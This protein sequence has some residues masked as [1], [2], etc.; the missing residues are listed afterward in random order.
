MEGVQCWL[1]IAREFIFSYF[2]RFNSRGLHFFFV[3][4]AAFPHST[5]PAF[6]TNLY[7]RCHKDSQLYYRR[8][9]ETGNDLAPDIRRSGKS[10]CEKRKKKVTDK[11]N[12]QRRRKV[13]PLEQELY[14]ESS[15]AQ[16]QDSYLFVTDSGRHILVERAACYSEVESILHELYPTLLLPDKITPSFSEVW[17]V[18]SL[19]C[20]EFEMLTLLFRTTLA[21]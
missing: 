20:F 13:S 11:G 3:D 14:S 16:Y 1:R 7:N 18:T 4:R 10:S 19:S 5:R 2:A 15:D 12:E 21:S 8:N 9:K 17:G 6:F